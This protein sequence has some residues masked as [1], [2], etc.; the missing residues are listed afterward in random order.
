MTKNRSFYL[1]RRGNGY[2]YGRLL[3][4]EGHI[5]ATK[6]T[7]ERE[8]DA[9][10]LVVADWVKNGIPGKTNNVRYSPNNVYDLEM[11]IKSIK[12]ADIDSA[13]AMTI[14]NSL[15]QKGLVNFNVCEGNQGNQN[16][17]KFLSDFWD[18][19]NSHYVKDKLAHGH[20]ITRGYTKKMAGRIRYFV[21][22]FEGR[23][24]SS[25][26]RS[27]LKSFSIALCD[28]FPTLRGATINEIM[29]A[30]LI[31]LAYAFR[32]KWIPESPAAEFDFF[33]KES[34]QRGILTQDEAAALF[35]RNWKDKKSYAGNMV[36]AT[37]GMRASEILA[38]KKRDILQDGILCVNNSLSRTDGL[39]TPKNG[40]SRKIPLLLPVKRLL[41]NIETDSDFIFGGKM[42][43]K[44]LIEGLYS[45]LDAM[46]ID[47]RGRN[48]CFHSWRHFYA[49]HITDKIEFQK[50]QKITGHLSTA[51]LEHYANHE[52]ES[53][54]NAAMNAGKTLFKKLLKNC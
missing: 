7:G 29:K 48:I 50:A 21:S 47:R 28:N 33:K 24:L 36:A 27:D 25:I 45:E 46:G 15:K 52:T 3:T 37:T 17:I 44:F 8:R 13:G 12:K 31:P 30:A 41:L 16:F 22:A 54:I 20:S 9:A 49:A 14:I 42:N 40:L 2:F 1:F 35:S 23:T 38:I 53:A 51:M 43:E 5:T 10:L 32:E 6:S 19:D 11:I 4:P 26:T 18:Y 34:R 39:K